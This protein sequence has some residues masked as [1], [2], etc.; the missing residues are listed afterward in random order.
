M[1]DTTIWLVFIVCGVMT[2][3]LRWA[4]I[5]GWGR[6]RLPVRVR[7]ALRFVPI[8]VLIAIIVQD[9]LIREG[10]LALAFDNYRLIAAL[11]AVGVA[12]VTRNIFLTIGAGFVTLLVLMNM[13]LVSW[14]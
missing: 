12:A 6:L 7:R 8:A 11:V 10:Q 9:T 3:L 4:F 14:G 13:P 2:F 5:V 1:N